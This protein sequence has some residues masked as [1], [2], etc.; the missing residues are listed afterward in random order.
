MHFIVFSLSVLTRLIKEISQC[1]QKLI[2][3]ALLLSGD[4]DVFIL[5]T[6]LFNLIFIWVLFGVFFLLPYSSLVCFFVL[7]LYFVGVFFFLVFFLKYFS[8]IC[9]YSLFIH[10]FYIYY[11]IIISNIISYFIHLLDEHEIK[12]CIGLDSM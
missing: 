4:N 1:I 12:G 2:S 11:T 3:L 9:W 10:V 5:N 6:A 7:F 8:F